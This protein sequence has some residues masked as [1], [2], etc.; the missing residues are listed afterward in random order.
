MTH[1]TLIFKP[2]QRILVRA[3][4]GTSRV[5]YTALLPLDQSNKFSNY[6]FDIIGTL[7][8]LV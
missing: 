8:E 1:K 5:Q 4:F 7:L 2:R 6:L 3:K